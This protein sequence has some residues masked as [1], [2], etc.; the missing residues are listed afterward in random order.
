M[1]LLGKILLF[2]NVLAALGF[3][4]MAGMDWGKRYAWAEAVVEHQLVID[5]VPL[6]DQ[7]K[8]REGNPRVKDLRE[9]ALQQLFQQAGGSPAKTQ[10]DEARRVKD[11]LLKRVDDPAV[12]PID[13]T[14]PATPGGK[15]AEVLMHFTQSMKERDEYRRLA[16]DDKKAD[17]MRSKV[18]G[19]F[20]AANDAARP[21]EERR[22]LIAHLLCCSADVLRYDEEGNPPPG[23][24]ASKAYQRALAT[25]GVVACARELDEETAVLTHFA[26]DVRAGMARD[27]EAY[28]EA[29]RTLIAQVEDLA[30]KCDRQKGV[31]KFQNELVDKQRTLAETRQNELLQMTK[32]LAGLRDATQEQL[33]I[34][35]AMEDQLFKSRK[36]QRDD[37]EANLKLERQLRSLEKGR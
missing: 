17:E 13:T 7:E 8:D 25:T 34:Q 21:P 1:S 36:E 28:L 29:T 31:L 23:L 18:E 5:G 32:T 20:N 19:L 4:L 24:V 26:E 14:L 16:A 6:D 12:K 11:A 30:E 35:A 37:L 33:A 2:L 15:L 10:V 22:G 9:K 27:R 3:F